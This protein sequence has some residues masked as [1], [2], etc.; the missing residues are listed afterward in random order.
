MKNNGQVIERYMKH[1]ETWGKS[2]NTILAYKSDISLFTK[3]ISKPL[4]ETT[5]LDMDDYLYEIKDLKSRSKNRKIKCI[6]QFFDWMVKRELIEKNPFEDAKSFKE[7]KNVVEK[8]NQEEIEN[9]EWGL[10][11]T[12]RNPKRNVAI[13]LTQLNTGMRIHELLSLCPKDFFEFEDGHVEIEIIG[14]GGK[15]RSIPVSKVSYNRLL[16]FIN[17]CESED[18]KLFNIT[19]ATYRNTLKKQLDKYVDRKIANP[20]HICRST[21]A[22][23]LLAQGL[24]V[25]QVSNLLG[26]ESLDMIK[27]YISN[28]KKTSLSFIEKISK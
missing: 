14:K 22:S 11:W 10:Q 6:R 23:N 19:E 24:D 1:L 13:F 15:K 5:I 4:S 26:H 20:T 28:D 27:F 16:D 3:F 2:T 9:I 12:T 17:A 7:E 18:D 21:F 8:L 25:V